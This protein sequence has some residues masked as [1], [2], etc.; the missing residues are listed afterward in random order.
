VSVV[1][2]FWRGHILNLT[3]AVELRKG[4]F[5]AKLGFVGFGLHFRRGFG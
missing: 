5:S 4:N 1:S 2:G 3:N